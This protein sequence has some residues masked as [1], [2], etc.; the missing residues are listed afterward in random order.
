MKSY[1]VKGLSFQQNPHKHNKSMVFPVSYVSKRKP[2][3][4]GQE[5]YQNSQAL[6]LR[7]YQFWFVSCLMS[8]TFKK[9]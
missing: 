4:D 9:R 7:V 6:K 1:S 2:K 3:K 8:V 5:T